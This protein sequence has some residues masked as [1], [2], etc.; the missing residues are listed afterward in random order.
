MLKIDISIL[1]T[2]PSLD[3]TVI[4][5]IEPLAPLSMVCELPGSYYKTVK[6]PTKKMLCGLIENLIGWHIDLSDRKNIVKD[7]V[8][9]RK[10][11]AKETS[12][13]EFI[14][15]SKGSSYLPLLMDYFEI[16]D[17]VPI[18]T[19][20]EFYDDLWS[21][22][23]RR[24]D[25]IVHPKGTFNISYDII[26]DKWSLGRNKKDTKQVDDKELELFFKENLS[27]F[28]LY[29]STPT[30]RE[31][32]SMNGFYKAKILLDGDLYELLLEAIQ[33]NNIAYLGN[34]EG[35]I[36]ITINDDV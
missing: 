20:A 10:K 11:Q 4:M 23:Y 25:A 27:K 2:L 32:I 18:F 22:A 19:K 31:Y 7:I 15:Y 26:R 33:T 28:P 30:K 17:I 9:F 34:S 24:A 3:K 21:K 16:I 13:L 8:Q 6:T 12:Q 1:K 36:N 35:W 29:Y 5:Q 14:D